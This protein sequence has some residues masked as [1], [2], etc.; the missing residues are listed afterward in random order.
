[1]SKKSA[2]CGETARLVQADVSSKK[3]ATRMEK[4]LRKTTEQVSF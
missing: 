2:N 3:W 1:M 4:N